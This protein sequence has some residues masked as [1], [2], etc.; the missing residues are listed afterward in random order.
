MLFL[1]PHHYRPQ[2]PTWTMCRQTFSS[3]ILCLVHNDNADP[4]QQHMTNI[5]AFKHPEPRNL[6]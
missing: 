1:P 3:D 5:S 6:I 2:T 4:C